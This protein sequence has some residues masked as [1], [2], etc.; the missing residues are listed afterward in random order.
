MS[1]VSTEHSLSF[2]IITKVTTKPEEKLVHRM[3][4]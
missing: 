1:N 2:P 4:N 3:K